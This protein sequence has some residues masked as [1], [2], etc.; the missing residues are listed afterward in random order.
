[1]ASGFAV[2]PLGNGENPPHRPRAKKS[3]CKSKKTK[4][5]HYQKSWQVPLLYGNISTVR[6]MFFETRRAPAACDAAG[7]RDS[8]VEELANPALSI[9]KYGDSLLPRSSLPNRTFRPAVAATGWNLR[10]FQLSA[11]R[12]PLSQ[13]NFPVS[14]FLAPNPGQSRL[15]KLPASQLQ[16]AGSCLLNSYF[17]F[18]LS[19]F[20][21]PTCKHV[22][23][24]AK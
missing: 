21:P 7:Q 18:L 24:L 23:N 3:D 10:I 6:G 5:E 1:L 8:H 9:T 11:F 14:E 4:L 2:G 17:R 15:I 20:L 13:R 12:F 19:A 16:P 22:D